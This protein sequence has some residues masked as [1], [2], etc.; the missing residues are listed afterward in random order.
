MQKPFEYTVLI[1]TWSPSPSLQYP[2]GTYFLS[3]DPY[4]ILPHSVRHLVVWLPWDAQFLEIARS[5]ALHTIGFD[6]W[7]LT[8]KSFLSFPPSV[9][10]VLP[11][12]I[13]LILFPPCQVPFLLITLFF[14]SSFCK[15]IFL[16]HS[17][18]SPSPPRSPLPYCLTHP[19][20]PV[21][22]VIAQSFLPSSLDHHSLSGSCPLRPARGSFIDLLVMPECLWR[23][24]STRVKHPA[25][26]QNLNST[27]VW[28]G[29]NYS[30]LSDHR[31]LSIWRHWEGKRGL[32][33]QKVSVEKT[34]VTGP[35][36]TSQGTTPQC[37]R[38]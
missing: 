31:A 24:R 22:Q 5:I 30:G 21:P 25:E 11:L 1:Q 15:S 3:C 35:V 2:A 4:F 6:P 27:S 19:P 16:F 9:V 32:I 26:P 7:G 33:T 37:C 36:L 18:G 8:N 10:L 12:I 20:F 17:T 23:L 28:A 14:I 13:P 29:I 38:R 34:N